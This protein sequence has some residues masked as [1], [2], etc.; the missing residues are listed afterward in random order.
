MKNPD[1]T[2]KLVK[3]RN[4]QVGDR[5]LNEELGI[6]S[7]PTYSFTT[8]EEINYKPEWGQPKLYAV[9][10]G[11][12]THFLRKV[13]PLFWVDKGIWYL[14]NQKTFEATRKADEAYLAAHL[15]P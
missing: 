4:L 12:W 8:I 9:Q 10:W 3:A 14:Q 2:A 6:G 11:S 5:I 1:G 15:M 13:N 7:S